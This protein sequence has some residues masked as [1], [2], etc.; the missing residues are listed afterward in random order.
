[1]RLLA[2]AVAIAL[3]AALLPSA[4][5]HNCAVLRKIDVCVAVAPPNVVHTAAYVAKELG[6]FARHCIDANIIQ[7]DG[8]SS[9]AA[10]VALTQGNTFTSVN[11]V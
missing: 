3:D 7:F 2:I 1:M 9:P 5:A 4:S 8:G 11:D 10:S 6:I